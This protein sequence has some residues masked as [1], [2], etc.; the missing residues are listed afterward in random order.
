M[1]SKKALE[2]FLIMII[3]GL[4][5]AAA[6]GPVG[7]A[8]QASGEPQLRRGGQDKPLRIGES[9]LPGDVLTAKGG[10]VVF[11]FCP[12]TETLTLRSGGIVQLMSDSVDVVQGP[13]L[14]R[15]QV[16][17]CAL[18]Q[19][20]LGSESLER[21]GALR[22]RGLPPIAVYLG[23]LVSTPRPIF[24][25]EPLEGNPEYAV[26][27][28]NSMGA[29]V[30]EG[31]SDKA[32]LAYP[33]S[34]PEL[35]SGSYLWQV[36]AK[37]DGEEVG[38]QSARFQIKPDPELPDTAT[39]AEDDAGRMLLAAA[40]ENAGYYAEAAR[41]YRLLRESHPEDERFTSRLAWLYWNAGLITAA[42]QER[43]KLQEEGS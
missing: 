8:L 34:E 25:W 13:E 21:V 5:A 19:V 26:V 18:P 3:T 1:L 17:K 2:F 6:S 11:L 38:Q 30:W 14:G 39:E 28:K 33:E 15:G 23:G 31:T 43:K 36:T 12:T 41:Q 27:L 29:V 10:D 16:R 20:A 40:L 42:G 24:E 7:L 35:E 4:P 32:R 22:A 9:L 37:E